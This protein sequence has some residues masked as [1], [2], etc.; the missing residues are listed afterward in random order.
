[1]LQVFEVVTGVQHGHPIIHK[2][3]RVSVAGQDERLVFRLFAHGGKR[4]DHIVAL[5]TGFFDICDAQRVKHALDKRQLAEQILRG[6]VACAF[7][8]RQHGVAEGAAFD[9]E[10][11]GEVIGLLRIDHLGEHGRE[12]PDRVGGLAGRGGEVLYGKSEER[13]ERQ[14]MAIN[15]QQRSARFVGYGI[16]HRFGIGMRFSDRR[17]PAWDRRTS[18]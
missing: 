2:L 6:G 17:A 18:R 4:A 8:L 11:N 9:V 12:A 10:C 14:R 15:D 16:N 5:V 3:E 13:A 7:V 1:M